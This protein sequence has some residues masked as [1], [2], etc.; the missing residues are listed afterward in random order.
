M[1]ET[2][3]ERPD[4]G[5]GIGVREMPPP[6]PDPPFQHFGVRPV[7]EHLGAV[8]ALEDQAIAAGKPLPESRGDET[9]VGAAADR[10]PVLSHPEGTGLFCIMGGGVSLDREVPYPQPLIEPAPDQLDRHDGASP[11]PDELVQGAAG[12]N[13]RDLQGPGKGKHPPHMIDMLV[14]HEDCLDPVSPAPG[15]AQPGQN[16]PLREPGIDKESRIPA[17]DIEAV[18]AAAACEC[19]AIHLITA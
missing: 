18:P 4:A 16:L 8:V 2:G 9:S 5:C 6:G 10:G 12:R 3:G 14:G 17:L 1:V 11:A 19:D 13:H 7:P 15:G